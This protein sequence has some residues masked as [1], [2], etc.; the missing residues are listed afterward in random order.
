MISIPLAIT[1][2][3][4]ITAS[5]VAVR[6]SDL[7]RE[8]LKDSGYRLLSVDAETADGSVKVLVAGH[9]DLPPMQRL[10]AE[11]QPILGGRS[12]ELKVLDSRTYAFGGG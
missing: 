12:L 10:E 8:W 4:L 5:Q 3:L 6:T 9:G 2:H 7:S 1:S 11:A